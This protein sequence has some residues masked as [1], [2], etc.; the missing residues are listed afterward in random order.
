MCTR[1]H[2]YA[3]IE[4]RLSSGDRAP[5]YPCLSLAGNP[6]QP[7]GHRERQAAS[8]GVQGQ[9]GSYIGEARGPIS[10]MARRDT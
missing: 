7:N 8:R 6:H 3:C 9:G 5:M 10:G 2:A 4:F 1:T